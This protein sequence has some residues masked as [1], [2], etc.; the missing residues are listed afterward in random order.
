M[1]NVYVIGAGMTKF[2]KYNGKQSPWKSLYDLGA[3]AVI[4]VSVSSEAEAGAAEKEG[5]SYVSVGS[6][7]PTASK[8]D[9]GEAIGVGPLG[10]IKRVVGLPVLAIGGVNC[11]NVQAVIR[12]GADGA[13]V[14]S[15]VAAAK[16]MVE[17]TRRLCSLIAEARGGQEDQE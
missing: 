1:G 15:A 10:R 4:G 17:A 13:A 12:A 6:V 8:P 14:I 16:D 7:F 3:E 5:A 2:G 9:A 11:D